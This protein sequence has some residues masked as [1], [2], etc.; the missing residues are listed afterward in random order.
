MHKKSLKNSFA[1]QMEMVGENQSKTKQ[2][3]RYFP[4]GKF[5]ETL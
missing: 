3:F 4:L 1:Y 2:Y 5:E